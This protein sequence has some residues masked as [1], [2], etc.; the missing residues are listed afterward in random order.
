[1]AGTKPTSPVNPAPILVLASASPRRRD[2][3]AQV[4]LGFQVR[5]ADIDETRQTGEAPRD[6]V[7]RLAQGKARAC[8]EA[9]LRDCP[10]PLVTALNR[11]EPARPCII[12]AADTI[13]WT[14][15]GAVLG[16]PQDPKA[17]QH[18]LEN[19][20]GRTHH[21][22]TGVCL[23]ELAPLPAAAA[24]APAAAPPAPAAAAPAPSAAPAA[25]APALSP[26]REHAFVETTDVAFHDLTPAQI[27]SY[28]ASGEPLDK[29]GSYGIQG[30]GCLLVRSIRG[31]Y[32][33]VVGLPL[34]RT[35]RELSA[36]WPQAADGSSMSLTERLLEGG[37]HGPK[38][39]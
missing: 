2:L 18:M 21:V 26:A 3:L 19:L 4:G 16:K 22:S 25:P 28:V 33:N 10:G 24:P 29:A 36:L 39:D 27:A 11:Q 38:A 32:D 34:S 13:V 7:R 12:L 1:M 8:A 20:S 15:E 35:I 14:D 30:L 23:L 9:I 37:S 5:P 31:D 6:L 17:A